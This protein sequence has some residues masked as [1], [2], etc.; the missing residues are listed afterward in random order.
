MNS[1]LKVGE[2]YRFI[3]GLH[4]NESFNWFSAGGIFGTSNTTI[5]KENIFFKSGQLRPLGRTERVE[6]SVTLS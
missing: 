5:F 6:D 3:V 4:P 2:E 1:W